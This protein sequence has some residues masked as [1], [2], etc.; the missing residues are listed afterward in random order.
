M[1]REL[2][3]DAPVNTVD[4]KERDLSLDLLRAAAIVYIVGFWHLQEYSSALSF[5]RSDITLLLTNCILALFFHISGYLLAKKNEF[6]LI[7]DMKVFYG[8][9]FIRIY[10]MY[11]IALVG[12]LGLRMISTGTFV[13][14]AL[15]TNM[16]TGE[17]LTTLWFVTL[18]MVFYL[19]TPLFL[20]RPGT[21]RILVITVCLFAFLV[22][23]EAFAGQTDPRFA[24]FLPAFASGILAARSPVLNKLMKPSIWTVVS[25]SALVACFILFVRTDGKQPRM[26]ITILAFIVSTP[27]FRMGGSVLASFVPGKLIR[28][29]SYASYAAYLLHRITF[30]IGVRIYQPEGI[31]ISVLYLAGICLPATFGIAY[32]FQKTNDSVLSILKWQKPSTS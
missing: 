13:R 24:M 19:I 31:A 6:L 12:Y 3:G 22:F 27:V 14:A 9:R 23:L 15:L 20:F 29:V 26:F 30:P 16:F 1:N 5:I 17:P 28:F 7:E 32:L 21:T 8:K 11:I 18:I 25:L 10:P 2:Q 4:N